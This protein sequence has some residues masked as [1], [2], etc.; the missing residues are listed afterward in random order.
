[1]KIKSVRDPFT[2]HCE[3][4]LT[5]KSTIQNPGIQNNVNHLF[6]VSTLYRTHHK[7]HTI[8]LSKAHNV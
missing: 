7:Y 1:M 4:Y 8:L 6:L 5:M 3:N 2:S